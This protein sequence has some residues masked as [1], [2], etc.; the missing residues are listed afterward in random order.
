MGLSP[1]HVGIFEFNLHQVRTP[2]KWEWPDEAKPERHSPKPGS[3]EELFQMYSFPPLGR[4]QVPVPEAQPTSWGPKGTWSVASLTR[5]GGLGPRKGNH[6]PPTHTLAHPTSLHPG[7]F[8]ATVY[9][10]SDETLGDTG[11]FPGFLHY[12]PS[13]RLQPA[14]HTRT[15][16]DHAR[17][18]LLC[19]QETVHTQGLSTLRPAFSAGSRALRP[20]SGFLGPGRLK[21]SRGLALTWG[22]PRRAS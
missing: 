2:R 1:E 18:P 17:P 4:S 20:I 9:L 5:P 21:A 14:P 7:P 13:S 19:P 16:P 12:D 11:R 6:E 22:P 3:P 8:T 10:G 15:Q